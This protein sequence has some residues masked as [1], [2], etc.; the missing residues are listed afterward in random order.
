MEGER[1]GRKSHTK[2]A[3]RRLNERKKGVRKGRHLMGAGILS[4]KVE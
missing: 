1:G 4:G 2:T 3:P